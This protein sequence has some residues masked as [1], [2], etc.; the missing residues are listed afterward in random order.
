MRACHTSVAPVVAVMCIQSVVQGLLSRSCWAVAS[1]RGQNQRCHHLRFRAG[2]HRA[3]STA[4][5]LE[6]S[7][8]RL[9]CGECGGAVSWQVQEAKQRFSEV[10][11][12]VENDGP[13]T[14]TRHGQEI[15]VVIDIEEYRQLT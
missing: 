7:L 10:L 12:A 15:A 2:R 6:S 13:Q 1:V 9:T 4:H 3:D 5:V 14:I 11:R 8:S